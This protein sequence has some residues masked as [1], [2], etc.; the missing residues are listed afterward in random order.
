MVKKNCKTKV[1]VDCCDTIS[2]QASIPEEGKHPGLTKKRKKKKS[3]DNSIKILES[4][5]FRKFKA[6][7]VVKDEIWEVCEGDRSEMRTAY[8]PEGYYIGSTKRAY[9][10]CVKRGLTKLQPVGPD[11][12]IVSLGFNEKENKWYGWSH[13]AIYG[14]GI[15][16]EVKKGDCG[17]FP[18]NKE[19]FIQSF[20]DSTLN[21][22]HRTEIKVLKT[23]VKVI[24]TFLGIPEDKSQDKYIGNVS[25]EIHPYPKQYGN[26]EWVAKTI[27]E[28]KL[29][30]IE[31]A[32]SVS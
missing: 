28:A 12:N 23:G 8:T 7:Y 2:N 24:S 6:G 16:S 14:F 13:R 20:E 4:K 3:N 26:G 30:A 9:R 22:H 10:L 15:G 17:Y 19:E 5:I 11:S 21:P 29:M 25:T 27:E 31:F 32:K 1:D 18:A